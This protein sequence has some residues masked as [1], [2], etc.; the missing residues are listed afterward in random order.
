MGY[1]RTHAPAPTRARSAHAQREQHAFLLTCC[2][3]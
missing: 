1:A 3:T 2:C